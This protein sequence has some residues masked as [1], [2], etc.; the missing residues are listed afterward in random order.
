MKI[1]N[2]QITDNPNSDMVQFTYGVSRHELALP[3]DEDGGIVEDVYLSEMLHHVLL[4]HG[5]R[6]R[7]AIFDPLME[8][9]LVPGEDVIDPTLVD[10]LRADFEGALCTRLSPMAA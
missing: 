10:E 5:H 3:P 1:D 8:G 4:N 7:A 9:M 6:L 2:F